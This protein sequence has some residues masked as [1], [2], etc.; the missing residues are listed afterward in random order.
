MKI[1]R[2][3]SVAIAA[4]VSTCMTMSMTV[5]HA[6]DEKPKAAAATEKSG[7]EEKKAEETV[8]VKIADLDL[9]IPK[10]WKQSDAPRAMRLATF[11]IP[12]AEGDKEQGELAVSSFPGGGGGIG[13]GH[14]LKRCADMLRRI[15]DS[16]LE[17]IKFF[18]KPLAAPLRKKSLIIQCHGVSQRGQAMPQSQSLT[19][20]SGECRRPR[21][22][23]YLL[24]LPY[25]QNQEFLCKNPEKFSKSSRKLL[26]SLPTKKSQCLEAP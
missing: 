10:S 23:F 20:S 25:G 16:M 9:K 19:C 13:I 14:M 8:D 2:R 4:L 1:P 21:Y 11:E 26:K 3:T 5:I 7:K 12:A 15:A 24:A 6:E 18:T 22:N 17:F